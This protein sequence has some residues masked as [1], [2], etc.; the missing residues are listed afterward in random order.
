MPSSVF[1]WSW[2][3]W[4][5]PRISLSWWSPSPHREYGLCGSQH[6][7]RR[8]S[9]HM[10]I[11]FWLWCNYGW[12]WV[13]LSLHSVRI[14]TSFASCTGN[15]HPEFSHP[16]NT[17]MSQKW[18]GGSQAHSHQWAPSLCLCFSC[19]TCWALIIGMAKRVNRIGLFLELLIA[20]NMG[21]KKVKKQEPKVS[22]E[23]Y[24]YVRYQ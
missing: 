22:D 10:Q 12:F 24:A 21:K 3:F 2:L 17:S 9:D 7:F 20:Y 23:S 11:F 16:H 6:R 13:E 5:H 4:C 15:L 19:L 14:F 1:S 18:V 8:M